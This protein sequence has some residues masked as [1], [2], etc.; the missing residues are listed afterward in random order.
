MAGDVR[1]VFNRFHHVG[2]L[3]N[4]YHDCEAISGV[5]FDI[6]S[7]MFVLQYLESEYANYTSCTA[8]AST[9]DLGFDSS[10]GETEVEV[11]WDQRSLIVAHAV[12]VEV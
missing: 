6:N 9:T 4:R 10:T 7:G 3:S 1:M 2:S 11:T 8:I 12:N 5:S